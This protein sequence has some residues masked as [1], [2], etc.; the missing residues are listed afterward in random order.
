MDCIKRK[1]EIKNY[2]DNL[3][4]DKIVHLCKVQPDKEPTKEE[5]DKILGKT[6]NEL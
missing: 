2:F 4:L 1:L 3:N 6:Q 5:I